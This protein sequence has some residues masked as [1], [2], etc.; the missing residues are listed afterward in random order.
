VAVSGNHTGRGCR[1]EIDRVRSGEDLLG[2]AHVERLTFV[3]Q[4][5]PTLRETARVSCGLPESGPSL[6]LLHYA[7]SYDTALDVLSL[8][9]VWN[10]T[11]RSPGAKVT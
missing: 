9:G 10:P 8:R 5:H 6:L 7:A 4:V 1:R 11:L 3:L 2:V